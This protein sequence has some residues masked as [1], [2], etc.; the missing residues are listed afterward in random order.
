MRNPNITNGLSTIVLGLLLWLPNAPASGADSTMWRAGAATE[1]ITPDTPIP[2]VGYGARAKPFEAVD[3]DIYVKALA[4]EDNQGTQGVI[5]TADLVGLQSIFFEESCRRIEARTGLKRE[6]I[7]LNAS[8]SHTGPLL[9]LNPDPGGNVAYAPFSSAKAA[10]DVADY[11]RELQDKIVAVV[12]AALGNLAP[13]SLSWGADHVEF[14]MNRRADPVDG[15]VW[16]RPNP[17]GP[18]DKRI[19]VMKVATPDGDIQALLLGCAC[20][21]TGLTADHNVISGDYAGYAQE[22]IEKRLPGVT[23]LFMSGCGADANP[24]PRTDIPGVRKLG[25]DLGDAVFRALASDLRPVNGP[26]KFA[27]EMANL[28]LMSLTKDE[29][30]PFAARKT[31]ENL[32]AKHMIKMLEQGKTL[33]THYP[34]PVAA[35]GF[36]DDL[37][38]VGLPSEVVADYALNLYADRPDTPLWVASYTND[39]FGYVPSAQ[40]VREGGHEFIG[41][42]TYLWGKDLG[43]QAGFFSEEVEPVLL[44]V[45]K[46]LIDNVK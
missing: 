27:Y 38:L 42:T 22:Y 39:L 29:L 6:Q 30:L 3:I 9:S 46:R 12:E 41:I 28:P 7:M 11:T 8:H 1:V 44:D 2:L 13:A 20:H 4:L 10:Q 5:V 17:K 24:E 40:I 36:G 31:T 25:R 14:V 34:A 19:P 35:W 21:N 32:M 15:V 37:V 26:L 45:A 16:M 33:P 43:T 23:A 18:T